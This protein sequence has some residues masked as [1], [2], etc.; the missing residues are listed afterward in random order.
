MS[1]NITIFALTCIRLK[2]REEDT[3]GSDVIGTIDNPNTLTCKSHSIWFDPALK[4]KLVITTI[5][6][7]SSR[8]TL[9]N[10]NLR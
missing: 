3:V 10:F 4:N 8:I 9:C 2:A 1:S 7:K 5:K 6:L